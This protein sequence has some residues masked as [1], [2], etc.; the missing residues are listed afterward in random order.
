MGDR[1]KYIGGSD[2]AGVLGLSR[3]KTPLMVWALKTGQI[4]EEDI[5]DRIEVKLG[6]KLEQTVA[7]LF[8]EETG[9]KVVRKNETIF[10]PNYPFLGANI[11]RRVIGE[12]AVLECKTATMWKYRE[13]EGQDIPQEYLI[14]VLH[15]M[16]VG[17]FQKGYIACLIGNH[18]FVWK[19][20]ERD[21]KMI[22]DLIKKEVHFWN[23]FV[24]PK[25]M[26]ASISANDSDI[27]Y[28]LYQPVKIGEEVNLGEELDR[29]AENLDSMR[30]DKK[31]LE[32]QV[33][34]LENEIKVKLGDKEIGLGNNWKATWKLQTQKRLNT[35]MLRREY[36]QIY[37]ECLK[38]QEIRILRISEIKEIR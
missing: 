28:Q 12:D 13:W 29:L 10:H 8:M 24:I 38:S 25:V 36:S 26:P 21:E 5:S 6:N 11:D 27:L 19:E 16:A 14:Q 4:V 37:E 22:A 15:Y 1:N 31:A 3:W 7:E 23:T 18:K 32:K 9:K 33:E 34:Q 30:A 2:A 35:E 17:N 20:I